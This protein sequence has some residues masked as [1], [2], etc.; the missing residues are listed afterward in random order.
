MISFT[1][2]QPAAFWSLGT[3]QVM[4][5]AV[6]AAL[7]APAN[8]VNKGDIGL[9]IACNQNIKVGNSYVLIQRTDNG[10]LIWRAGD[11]G[12]LNSNID[13]Q[14]G[15]FNGP[16]E[17]ISPA[18]LLTTTNVYYQYSGATTVDEANKIGSRIVANAA[19]IC[20]DIV[21]R[22]TPYND[23][24][25]DGLGCA[26]TKTVGYPAGP[27]PL[28][29]AAPSTPPGAKASTN[30]VDFVFNVLG[31]SGDKLAS[32]SGRAA[33]EKALEAAI[34]VGPNL[35]VNSG[36]SS[37]SQSTGRAFDMTTIIT[38]PFSTSTR[39]VTSSL[40]SSVFYSSSAPSRRLA[41]ADEGSAEEAH[42]RALQAPVP[43][44]MEWHATVVFQ[45]N[46]VAY[47]VGAQ[48][49]TND[50]AWAKTLAVQLST[51]DPVNFPP[52]T[53]DTSLAQPIMYP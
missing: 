16:P 45:S 51:L 48:L 8:G 15:S 43:T 7:N 39:T 35:V 17:N 46:A 40:G 20:A 10:D 21:T 22:L 41:A 31:V 37:G 6:A 9:I 13:P 29:S 27:T 2:I 32:S 42:A 23:P 3:T 52:G 26:I 19:A 14:V 28:P 49:D 30:Y 1:N 34:M 12:E 24:W 44:A 50:M 53:V 36:A 38:Q 11:P 47:Q 4:Q 33:L 25:A 18:G 5:S